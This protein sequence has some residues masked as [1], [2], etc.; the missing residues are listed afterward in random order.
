[1]FRQRVWTSRERGG[2]VGETASCFVRIGPLRFHIP[3]TR[4]EDPR[5]LTTT[6]DGGPT[7]GVPNQ[8]ESYLVKIRGG[9]DQGG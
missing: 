5:R 6:L 2:R 9:S 1:M 4:P 8:E 7:H 3:L